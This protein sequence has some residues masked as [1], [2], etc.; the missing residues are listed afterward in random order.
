[1]GFD[2]EKTTNIS[3]MENQMYLALWFIDG[4]DLFKG[5][6]YIQLGAFGMSFSFSL[7][8]ASIFLKSR[9]SFSWIAKRINLVRLKPYEQSISMALSWSVVNRTGY[10]F[11]SL[12][13]GS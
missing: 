1:M 11:D 4:T 7:A 12:L 8:A 6:S 9:F 10:G 5:Y 3:T 13:I 2:I